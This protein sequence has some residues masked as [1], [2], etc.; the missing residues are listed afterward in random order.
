[1]KQNNQQ[2]ATANKIKKW[3][4]ATKEVEKA[5]F[6]ICHLPYRY[7]SHS[8]SGIVAESVPMLLEVAEFWCQYYFAQSLSEKFPSEGIA[9]FD[10]TRENVL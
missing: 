6:A 2:R 1:M 7:T 3:I 5:R 4:Q 10:L 8:G 9:A